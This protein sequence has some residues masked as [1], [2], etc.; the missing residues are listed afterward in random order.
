MPR[1]IVTPELTETLRS[2]RISNNIQAKALAEHIGKSPAYISRLEH[3]GIQTIDTAE[4]YSILKFI[5]NQETSVG[6][7]D[8]I[9][10]SLKVKYSH[11]EIEDQL[12][13][14][15]FDTVDCFLPIPE[16]LVKEINAKIVTLGITRQYLN[17][18]INANEA[19]PAA[20]IENDSIVYN[21]WYH[22]KEIGGNA[23]SIKIKLS[24]REQD[25][26]LDGKIDVAPYVFVFCIVFYLLK[27]EK[28]KEITEIS[29]EANS[30]LM[31]E[32]TSLLNS[33]K[34][35]SIS[36][37]N[38]LLAEQSS[39]DD[40]NS[41]LSSFD[42]DNIDII[43]DILSG[44]IL[45]SAKNIKSTNEQLKLFGQNMHWDLGFMLALIS[46]DFKSLNTT[47]VS[48]RKKLLQEIDS[49]IAKYA[50]I[51]EEQ[52]RIEEY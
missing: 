9:Y 3:G 19:L 45:A 10:N 13:F 1:A 37:K 21:R 43:S 48:N 20:D 16:D 25:G 28:Y 26:I 8:Q 34:F 30:E 29:D 15:N 39:R 23:Q 17:S 52:N 51:P 2:V 42:N 47:S 18:R 32:T 33:H 24:E 7:A 50:S 49:I 5:T 36:E 46:R 41:L 14:T 27:I 40:L 6:L 22:Q 4:L 11:K 31:K 38:A 44:F 35:F 12:W